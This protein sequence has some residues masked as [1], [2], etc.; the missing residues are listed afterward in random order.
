MKSEKFLWTAE[1]SLSLPKNGLKARMLG[2]IF[3][4]RIY[5]SPTV[6]LDALM[7]LFYPSLASAIIKPSFR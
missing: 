5:H 1:V 6:L 4:H 7:G 2:L 3:Q